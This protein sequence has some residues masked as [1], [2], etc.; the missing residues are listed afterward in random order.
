MREYSEK[1]LSLKDLSQ[2]LGASQGVTA[3]WG[4]YEFLASPSAGALYPIDTYLVIHR[5]EELS[6]GVYHYLVG[7]H[8]L[9]VLARGDFR[10]E[11]AQAALGQ[12]M[13]ATAAVVFIWTAVIERSRRKYGQRCYRYIYLDAG[14]IA[15]NVALAAVSLGLGSCMIG[16]LHDDLVNQIIRV[17][18]IEETVV[19]MASAGKT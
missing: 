10:G 14:H 18:G 6:P 12:F 3:R 19:Y 11:V 4:S 1:P 2:L 9:E 16:A 8:R 17:D 5:V 7:E 13:A 15:Q